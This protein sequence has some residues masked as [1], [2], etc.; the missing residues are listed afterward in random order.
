MAGGRAKA[1]RVAAALAARPA[2]LGDGLSPAPR[3]VAE[4]LIELRKAG[5]GSV[6]APRCAGCGKPLRTIQRAGQDWYCTMCVARPEPCAACGSMRRVS[7]RDRAG[8][9][10]CAKCPD[11]D[12]RDPVT[13]ITAQVTML[14][15]GAG[16]Q[17]IA[18]AVRQAA[19]RP[20]HQQRLARALEGNP[21]LLTGAGHL[22]PVPAVLRLIDLLNDGGISAVIRPACPRCHRRVR[23]AKTLDGQRVCRSCIASIQDRAV[24]PLRLTPGTGHPRRP[25]QAAVPE[26][27][28]QRP[29]Q[30]GDLPELR[31]PAPREHPHPRRAAVPCLPAA[32]DPGLLDLRPERTMRDLPADRPAMV[33]H[34]PAAAG[35]LR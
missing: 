6:S 10:R 35:A 13:V 24:R 22:A 27:P 3:A 15:P 1:R 29:G 28:D 33:C 17:I 8:Q 7:T 21:R 20:S 14:E 31:S 19:P 11:E 5:A 25:G 23:V 4:L 12:R 32:A 16:P 2:V 30:F 26:L 18:A 34:L 9:P